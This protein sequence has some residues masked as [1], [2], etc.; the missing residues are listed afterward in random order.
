MNYYLCSVG[1]IQERWQKNSPHLP[2]LHVIPNICTLWSRYG[3]Y[4]H[5]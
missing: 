2:R 3:K 5:E 1:A 4:S